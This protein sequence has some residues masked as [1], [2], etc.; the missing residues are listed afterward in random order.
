MSLP[1]AAAVVILCLIIEGFFSGSEMA[2]MQANRLKLKAEAD[3]GD[4]GARLALELLENEE[5]LFALCLIGTN[6]ALVTWTTVATH[7]LLDLGFDPSATLLL[8]PLGLVF[9]EALP[10]ATYQY[11]A[12]RLAVAVARPLALLRSVMRPALAVVDV[13]GRALRS[14]LGKP[15]DE[16]TREELLD[17][18]DH[19]PEGPIREEDR[20]F[21]RG[22]LSLKETTACDCM[23][24]LIRVVAVAETATVAVTA[25]TAIRT[26]HSKLPVF[27]GRIDH[28]VG[29]V[30][31]TDLLFVSDDHAPIT[32]HMHDVR[33]V[34][35][36]KRADELLR[37][38]RATG[39]HFCVV[40]DEFGGCIGVVTLEDLL[41]ELV[42]DI[43]DER[44]V[45]R[46]EI[47]PTGEGIWRMPG[48]A[49][50]G[51]VAE[52]LGVTFPEGPYETIAGYVLFA[53]GRIPDAGQDLV[54]GDVTFMVEEASDRAVKR[55]RAERAAPSA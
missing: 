28:I 41:E 17:M 31:Q 46:P 16:L 8:A 3:A 52:A 9:G 47:A 27:R 53:L 49:D 4:S 48:N 44:A 10:K 19:N 50:L 30:Y 20:E 40:V 2:L 14:L 1:V 45:V 22:V 35:E 15:E 24:P 21:I 51:D 55:L 7:T 13:W 33:F 39:E 42:G 36:H 6:L 18:L 34:P 54:V 5:A 26:Q 12:D 38:M 43:E 37:E 29:V 25:E 32:Q 11:H 23:T